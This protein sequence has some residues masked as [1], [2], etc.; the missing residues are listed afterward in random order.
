MAHE[1]FPWYDG[2][3]GAPF[4]V[5]DGTPVLEPRRSRDAPPDVDAVVGGAIARPVDGPHL[6]ELAHGA[7][8]VL[9]L[10]D[11]AT[12]STRAS[13]ILPHVARELGE[14]GVDDDRV[15]LLTAQGTHRRMTREEV[16]R[17]VGAAFARRWRV[18][19]H[20]WRDR[21][22]LVRL[23]ETRAGMPVVVNRL[24]E[25]ADVVVGIGHVGVHGIMGYSGGAKIVLPGVCGGETES[26]THWTAGWY[27]QEELMG[28]MDGPIR[29]EI[30]EGARLAG[31]DAVVDVVMDGAGAV[32]HAAF[33]D[34]V[35]AQ[36]ACA[37][38]ARRLYAARLDAPHDVVVTDAHPADR[39]Y[40][41][42][43]KGLYAGTIAVREGG[44]VV[45][46][47]PNPEGVASNHP[48]C[49]ELAGLPLEEI[50]RRVAAGEV[51]DVI[52]AAVAAY[53][54][55]IRE[56]SDVYLVSSGIAQRDA[57]RMGFTPF[58]SVQKALDAARDKTG[59]NA[60]VAVLKH[61]G[62]LLPIVAARNEHVAEGSPPEARAAAP[63]ADRSP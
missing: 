25:E 26:W 28:V 33:G 53:T 29:R 58:P 54:A 14:A 1:R 49:V 11:D 12:R 20:D 56:R 46:V 4:E 10:V 27:A 7:R 23:G 47:C 57:R 60:S 43:V 55:R 34:L 8:R 37:R 50:R 30:E 17:K 35:Q 3:E 40:W 42:S 19:Q 15:A 39:D 59:R 61:A 21:D 18:H 13:E 22:G 62:G 32:R 38:E 2:A 41:Q 5:P 44:V 63:S 16:E 45:L 9:L 31:L 24:V 36:R 6:A 48:N 52:G 51:E